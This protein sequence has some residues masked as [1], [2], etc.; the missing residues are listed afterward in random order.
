[1]DHTQS[2]KGTTPSQLKA[3]PLNLDASTSTPAVSHGAP[4]AE[5]A[6]LSGGGRSS[7]AGAPSAALP[8]VA[9]I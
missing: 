9:T 4:R 2:Q 8:P 3:A 6:S 1:M 5:G 7:T